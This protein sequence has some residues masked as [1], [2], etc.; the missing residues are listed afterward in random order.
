MPLLLPGVAAAGSKSKPAGPVT[1]PELELD[2][3]RK[4]LYE[5]SVS[6]EREVK[7]KRR[8]WGRLLDVVAGEPDFHA[9]ISSLQRGD[10]FPGPHHCDRPG[11][12]RHS[13]L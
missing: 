2:G 6:S 5:G 4:L 13:Y 11:R 12:G 7:T 8:F 10:R 1:V 3:G 9:L